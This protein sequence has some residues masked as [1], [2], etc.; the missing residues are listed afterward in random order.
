MAEALRKRSGDAIYSR[1]PEV[2][3]QIDALM[4]LTGDERTV[5]FSIVD[6]NDP[7][8]VSSESLLHFLRR[9]R[10]NSPRNYESIYKLL[11][12]RVKLALPGG[13]RRENG[14]LVASEDRAAS[15]AL[16]RFA[17]L[18][19]SDYNGYDERLD[20][21]EVMFN[22]AVAGLR[23]TAVANARKKDTREAQLPDDADAV[24]AIQT[25]APGFNP[26]AI[27]KYSD[28]IY[29]IRMRDA[30]DALPV[31]Q[32]MAL[33][34]DWQG[35]PFTS[36][37]PDIATIGSYIGC[38]EQAARQKRDKAHRAIRIALEGEQE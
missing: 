24:D 8:F 16:A 12:E 37:D 18:L 2:E 22:A 4:A 33:I 34:L 30:I 28:P 26:L 21:F 36:T 5:R 3:A 1:R 11:L 35:V 29:R 17:E 19:A 15:A 27:E 25:D 32:R 38:G 20:F 10:G 6:G 23:R 7:R 13:W 14:P 9:H 31:D